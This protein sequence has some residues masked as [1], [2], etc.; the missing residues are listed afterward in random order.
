MTAFVSLSESRDP[1]ES[2]VVETLLLENEVDVVEEDIL[3]LISILVVE[4]GRSGLMLAAVSFVGEATNR[5]GGGGRE[6]G[7][8]LPFP[9]KRDH[10]GTK[11]FLFDRRIN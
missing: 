5:G 2:L 11:D 8:L 1:N 10:F 7:A 4:G 6:R 3:L 9:E